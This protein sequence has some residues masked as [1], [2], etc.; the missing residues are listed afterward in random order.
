MEF[1]KKILDLLFPR[2]C[3]I[4]D[5]IIRD[6]YIHDKCIPKIKIIGKKSCCIC[7]KYIPNGSICR[8]CNEHNHYY[9]LGI[10][11]FIYTGEL[12]ESILRF[13]YNKRQEYAKFFAR[14]MA[15]K[16]LVN[17][18]PIDIIVPV[19]IHRK[20]LVKRGYNQAELLAKEIASIIDKPFNNCLIRIKNTK[21]LNQLDK[22]QRL[23]TMKGTIKFSGDNIIDKDILIVDDIYTTGTT[24]D[25]CANKLKEV[26][27]NKV[28]F[29]TIAS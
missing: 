16:I 4:C 14:E 21:P 19:P 9:D 28:Y 17:N 22:N 13:K 15:K 8:E 27:A 26:G 10:S 23:E 29:I 12:K 11:T 2:R 25:I 5:E 1:L 18:I 6:G 24:I 20:R 3:P 7:G